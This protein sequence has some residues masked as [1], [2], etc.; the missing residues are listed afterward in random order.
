MANWNFN[1]KIAGSFILVYPDGTCSH[2]YVI[3]LHRV[4]SGPLH[5]FSATVDHLAR[6]NSNTSA[7]SLWYHQ[8][9]SVG[10]LLVIDF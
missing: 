1:L 9:K 2:S 7:L 10:G 8:I 4:L 3:L 6:V 5:L